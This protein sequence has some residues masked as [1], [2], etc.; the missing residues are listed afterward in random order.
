[1]KIIGTT[2]SGVIVEMSNYEA[3]ELTGRKDMPGLGATIEVKPTR[4]RI[5]AIKNISISPQYSSLIR[6]TEEVLAKL[7]EIE[8]ELVTV[9]EA[10]KVI[11]TTVK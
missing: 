5:D 8:P 7:K 4:S 1:M 3:L 11:D 9:I 2:S 10:A 6:Q